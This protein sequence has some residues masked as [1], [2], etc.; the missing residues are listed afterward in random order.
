M[1]LSFAQFEREVTGERIRDKI[2]ASK[3]KGI[4]MGG[5]VP[6]GYAVKDR[7]L[8]INPAEAETVRT[9]FRLYLEL[10]TVRRLKEA[11]DRLGLVTKRRQLSPDRAVGGQ[12]FTR[13]H[14]Y[15]L[16]SNPIYVG[17]VVHKGVRYAGR[18]EPIIDRETFGVAQARLNDNAAARQSSS[19]SKATSLLSG[20]IYDETRAGI[21]DA[22][23]IEIRHG[24]IE[25]GSQAGRWPAPLQFRERGD[26]TQR[27][28]SGREF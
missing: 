19:N 7:C 23:T 26:T 3:K 11:A 22:K 8:L 14:L 24:A 16:L 25:P 15:Q 1:L 27:T 28:P 2:A 5:L 6:L 13:G 9:L 20:L 18:H 12:A 10:G 17:E 21:S 4:W